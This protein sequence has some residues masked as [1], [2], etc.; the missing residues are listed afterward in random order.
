MPL[1]QQ[2][3]GELLTQ[4]TGVHAVRKGIKQYLQR[5]VL[6]LSRTASFLEVEEVQLVATAYLALELAVSLAVMV[7]LE[8]AVVALAL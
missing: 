4:L 2:V 1:E 5:V 6:C 7:A 8:L 3:P